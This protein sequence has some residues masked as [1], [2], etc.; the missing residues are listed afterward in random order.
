MNELVPGTATDVPDSPGRGP[1]D[2]EVRVAGAERSAP[3]EFVLI[4]ACELVPAFDDARQ[5]ARSDEAATLIGCDS[6][7]VENVVDTVA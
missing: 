7:C 5:H 4:G 2:H 6:G 3:R 1:G